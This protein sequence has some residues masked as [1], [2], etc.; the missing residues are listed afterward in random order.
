ML[1]LAVVNQ[2]SMHAWCRILLLAAV[3]FPA[4]G[5]HRGVPSESQSP[6]FAGDV[7]RGVRAFARA[8]AHDVTQEG[9]AAWRRHFM[10]SPTFFMAP[11]GRLIFPNSASA[12]T[13]IQDLTRMI[14]H[15]E[16]QWGDDLRVDPLAPNLAVMAASYHEIRV[17]TAGKQL[18][19]SGFFTGTVESQGGRWQ[20]RNAHWSVAGPPAAVR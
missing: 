1:A 7:D 6:A 19:E 2:P 15:I 20:F 13:G 5:C 4:C 8:V 14:R 18:D 17:D 16:L 3:L 12:T 9:P 11:E 10:D